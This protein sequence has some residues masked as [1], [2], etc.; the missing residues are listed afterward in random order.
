MPQLLAY[1]LQWFVLAIAVVATSTFV[2]TGS[3]AE[4]MFFAQKMF[5]IVGIT[6]L[7]QIIWGHRLPLV[8]GPA[9]YCSWVSS[10]RSEHRPRSMPSIPRYSLAVRWWHC[11]ARAMH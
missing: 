9:P 1:G 7:I 6:T 8:V 4:K 3:E 11:S 10:P 5:A 2:A